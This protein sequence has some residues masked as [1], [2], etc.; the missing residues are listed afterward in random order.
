MCLDG[1]TGRNPLRRAFDLHEIG[2]PRIAA[3]DG[4]PDAGPPADVR[5][6][7]RRFFRGLGIAVL[8]LVAVAFVV[9]VVARFHD[10]PIGPFKGGRLVAGERVNE[11]VADWSF[12][13]ATNRLE[14]ET[15]PE[16]PRSLTTWLLVVDRQL[17]V[18]SGLGARKTWPTAVEADPRV[19]VRLGG[20]IYELRAARVTDAETLRRLSEASKVKYGVGDAPP[21]ESTFYYHLVPRS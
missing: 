18:P 9:G 21:Y 10:G 17:Y 11:P 7:M 6:L 1:G 19:R 16:H 13:T 12:A 5:T 2:A 4:R 14:L 8:T 3:V 15:T 20:K